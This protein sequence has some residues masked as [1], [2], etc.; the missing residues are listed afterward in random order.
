[1]LLCKRIGECITL[2]CRWQ[3]LAPIHLDREHAV[4]QVLDVSS[5]MSALTVFLDIVMVGSAMNSPPCA[6]LV[7]RLRLPAFRPDDAAS[8]NNR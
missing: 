3:A 5:L 7:R 4:L 6:T 2:P 8:L 1:M